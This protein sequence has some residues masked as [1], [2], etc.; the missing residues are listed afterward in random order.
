M[1]RLALILAML[2]MAATTSLGTASARAGQPVLVFAAASTRDAMEAAIRAFP[3]AR[4]RGVYAATSALSRQ[5]LDGAPASIFLSANKAWADELAKAGIFKK[6]RDFLGNRLVLIA[7]ADTPPAPPVHQASD[8]PAALLGGRLAM[9]E[10]R[11]VPA[12]MYGR[13]ALTALGVWNAVENQ[14]APTA[15]V[16]AALLLVERGEAPLG[17]VYATDAQ[18]SAAVSIAWSIPSTAHD[19]IVYPLALMNTAEGGDDAAA[20]FAFLASPDGR[21]IFARHGFETD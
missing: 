19:P 16:R 11:S 9:A 20:F 5:I 13:Q 12:G 8:I 6:R 15:N 7:P 14:I 1:R 10:T 18:A 17:V 21:R 4:V 2:A 3:E